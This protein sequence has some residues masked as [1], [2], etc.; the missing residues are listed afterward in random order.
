MSAT[1]MCK[2]M[3]LI[4]E[5]DGKRLLIG[6]NIYVAKKGYNFDP[7]KVEYF[8]DYYDRNWNTE[9]PEEMGMSY[10]VELENN[11]WGMERMFIQ[12]RESDRAIMDIST[13]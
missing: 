6:D 5:D 9:K 3:K 12:V 7:D 1:K 8:P 10:T 13:E 11:K 2:N 4:F